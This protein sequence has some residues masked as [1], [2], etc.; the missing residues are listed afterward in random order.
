[1]HQLEQNSK[2][3]TTI[4]EALQHFD[5]QPLPIAIGCKMPKPIGAGCVGGSVRT[6]KAST[7]S[8]WQQ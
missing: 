7:S 5:T 8:M 6:D 1:M 3:T 4:P 2:P